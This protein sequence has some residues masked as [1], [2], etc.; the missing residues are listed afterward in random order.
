MADLTEW[1]GYRGDNP[2]TCPRPL[3]QVRYFCESV[4]GQSIL[5]PFMGSG[6][7]GVAVLQ[8]GKRFIGIEQDAV[9]ILGVRHYKSDPHG[10][11]AR[12]ISD[13]LSS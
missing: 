7:A 8:T 4:R 13:H 9:L 5:D 10:L 11:L 2:V 6:T 3:Q 12:I 1:D